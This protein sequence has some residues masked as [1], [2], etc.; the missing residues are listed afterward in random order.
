SARLYTGTLP[1][2]CIAL[3]EP[4]AERQLMLCLRS[5]DALSP[6]AQLLV[7]H[8]CLPQDAPTL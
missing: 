6:V 7:E 5:Q 8:L 4:W 3:D 2:R 1:L